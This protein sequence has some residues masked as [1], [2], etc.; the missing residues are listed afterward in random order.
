MHVSRAV[1]LG[2]ILCTTAFDVLKSEGLETAVHVRK[3]R[4]EVV[5]YFWHT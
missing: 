4:V 3:A 5:G 1:G 2:G